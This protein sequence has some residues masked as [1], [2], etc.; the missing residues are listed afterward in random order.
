MIL[1]TVIFNLFCSCIKWPSLPLTKV[2]F[3]IMDL[4]GREYAPYSLQLSAQG[5]SNWWDH[6]NKTF[7]TLT[8]KSIKKHRHLI[9]IQ[10]S[11]ICFY[12]KIIPCSIIIML[13][14]YKYSIYLLYIVVILIIKRNFLMSGDYG[15]NLLC[16][17]LNNIYT[18]THDKTCYLF[19]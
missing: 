11:I 5:S 2:C 10:I 16:Y 17:D 6:R 15:Q 4:T 7:F 19:P 9:D 18:C 1:A 8:L 12:N 14:L 13:L 3:S